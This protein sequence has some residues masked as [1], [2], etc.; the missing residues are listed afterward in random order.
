M[1]GKDFF[2]GVLRSK[3]V[4]WSASDH[5]ITVEWSQA[6]VSIVLKPGPA[7][8]KASLRPS[9]RPGPTPEEEAQEARGPQ[10]YGDR[11]QELVFIGLNMKEAK[12]RAELDRA[13]VT[14]KEF[15][16]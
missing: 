12:I 3:G 14:D 13:L 7:W 4:I 16:L 9:S 15:E 1:L 6:G 8:A 2:P 5:K 10:R 11:R